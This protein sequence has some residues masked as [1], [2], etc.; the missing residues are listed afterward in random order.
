MNL[1]SDNN[2]LNTI[3]VDRLVKWLS[4]IFMYLFFHY[5]YAHEHTVQY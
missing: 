2:I 5:G 3:L 4:L 1:F